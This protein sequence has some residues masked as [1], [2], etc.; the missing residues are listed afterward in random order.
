MVAQLEVR[1]G[2]VGLREVQEEVEEP[3]KDRGMLGG[4]SY[5]RVCLYG[6]L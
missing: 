2:E 4:C 1:E 6:R 3:G 5:L